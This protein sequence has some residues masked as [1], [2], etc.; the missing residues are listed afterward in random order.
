MGYK[1]RI[2]LII[3]L[4]NLRCNQDKTLY[5]ASSDYFPL[6]IGTIWYYANGNDTTV[7]EVIGDTIS[8][9]YH[10]TLI[11]RNLKKEFWVKDKTTIKKFVEKKL[12]QV[13]YDYILE[14]EFRNYFQLPLIKNNAWRENYQNT[15]LVLGDTVHIN[16]TI[17]G[18][19]VEIES[20]TTP[21]GKFNEVYKVELIDS[22]QLKD[23]LVVENSRYWL[24]PEVGIVKQQFFAACTAEQVLIR[25]FSPR[26]TL[27]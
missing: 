16:H 10:C 20:I 2:V 15:A 4:L 12:T 14:Q 25:F 27:P 22:L 8:Y 24:A 7:V 21:A 3:V 23:S 17:I 19:V 5:R 18:K 6:S 9:G 11:Y 13:G 26:L 1:K